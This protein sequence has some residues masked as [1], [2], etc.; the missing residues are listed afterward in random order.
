MIHT[1][2]NGAARVAPPGAAGPASLVVGRAMDRACGAR[3]IPGNA[4]RHFATGT[5]AF[6]AMRDMIRQAR[7][8]IHFENY[9]MR[10]DATGRS[11]GDLLITAAA[12]GVAVKVL[13]DRVGSGRTPAAFFR[14]LRDAG[15]DVRGFGRFRP[16]HALE[17]LS[18]DHRKY[19]AVDG[20]VA[21]LGGMCIGDEWAGAGRWEGRPWRDTAIQVR[22]PAVSALELTFGRVWAASG[23]PLTVDGVPPAVEPCGDA[24]VRVIDGVPGRFRVHRAVELLAT[25][26]A[27]RLWVT[28]AYLL[29]PQ[30]MYATLLAAARDGVDVRLLLPGHSDV[31][32][33]S[34]I[35]RVGYR[36]LLAAGVRIWEWRGPMLHSKTVLADGT[37][38]K[39][40]SSNLNASSLRH[41][42]ELDVLIEDKAIVR[43]A[44]AQF[45]VDLS[46]SVEVVLRRT[47][48]L[49][50][51]LKGLTA[52]APPPGASS[53]RPKSAGERSR[54]AVASLRQVAEGAR[55]SLS[56]AMVFGLLGTA[57][58][59]VA[60]PRTM[61]YLLAFACLWAGGSAAWRYFEWRRQAED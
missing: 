38:F 10:N 61:S 20:R 23:A 36:E 31:W 6:D 13:Y 1:L 2:T 35:S 37:W 16:L 39:V 57:A 42:Q 56:G 19:L 52:S 44:A 55:R 29:P 12:R 17:F 9:I 43:D 60:L 33:F 34:A 15:V 3:A 25:G 54:Q 14:R 50:L 24:T 7:H 11:F 58:L 48:V 5:A 46:Q 22:G 40:G 8:V 4:V 41:N 30:T 26:A 21:V 45:R 27:N 51:P 28:E 32:G 18:R 47:R 49:G 59:L 53:G